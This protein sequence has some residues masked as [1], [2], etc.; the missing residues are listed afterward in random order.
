M[1]HLERLPKPRILAEKEAEWQD[2]YEEKLALNPK[3]RPD[4][5]KYAHKEIKDT[6]NAMSYGKCFYCETKLSS[7][8]QE[9]D[10]F[11]EVAIDHSKAY[12]W[13]NL[14]LACSNCN[15]KIDHRVIPVD[16]V[17]DPCSDSD[18]EIQ[19][20]I[21]FVDE[22]ICAVDASEKGMRTIKKY[23][24]GTELLNMKRGKW[25]RNLMKDVIGIDEKMR[26]EGRTETTEEERRYLRH[27][28]SPDQ[29]YSLMCEVFI[30]KNLASL[31]VMQHI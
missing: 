9:V 24:L 2:K 26:Q 1:R 10:H 18:E 30:K 12:D 22:L 27:F 6:L 20:H 5:T 17:L 15:N 8:I 28:M 7:D 31:I 23:K 16:S 11:V 3:A 29:P 25:L 21:T 13:E 14:Y 4:N 19:R